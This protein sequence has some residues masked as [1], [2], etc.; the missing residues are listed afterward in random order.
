MFVG[1]GRIEINIPY[2][3]SLKEKRAVINSIKSKIS[4]RFNVSISEVDR[5]N[6]KNI[7]VIGFSM[8]SIEKDYINGAFEKILDFVNDSFDIVVLNENYEIMKY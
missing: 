2:A 3:Q 5:V 7:G 4:N 6:S 8:V 1:A